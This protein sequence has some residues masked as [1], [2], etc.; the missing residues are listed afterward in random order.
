[1]EHWLL[2]SGLVLDK[3][4]EGSLVSRGGVEDW[5]SPGKWFLCTRKSSGAVREEWVLLP[6]SVNEESGDSRTE[7]YQS[8]PPP[9]DIRDRFKRLGRTSEDSFYSLVRLVHISTCCPY[10]TSRESKPE[11]ILFRWRPQPPRTIH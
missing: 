3:K 8:S 5:V 6:L 9:I 2:S 1:M 11:Q 7:I 10:V 4:S